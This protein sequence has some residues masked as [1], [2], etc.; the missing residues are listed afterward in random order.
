MLPMSLNNILSEI[1]P[2]I[3]SL[4]NARCLL[5]FMALIISTTNNR[6]RS[7]FSI[8]EAILCFVVMYSSMEV[9]ETQDM[10]YG[11]FLWA[12]VF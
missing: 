9:S 10:P 2:E 3:A 1:E 6:R 4:Q 8:S 12:H 11:S 7:D 5:V